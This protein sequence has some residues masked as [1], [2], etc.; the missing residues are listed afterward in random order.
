MAGILTGRKGQGEG[1]HVIS[2]TSTQG[3][4]KGAEPVLWM[5]DMMQR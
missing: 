3:W 4:G 2:S 1:L 5:Q